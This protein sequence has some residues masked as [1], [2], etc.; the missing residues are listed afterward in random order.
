MN[1]IQKAFKRKCGLRMATGGVLLS[2]GRDN[3]L[4]RADQMGGAAD[5]MAANNN[6]PCG[7]M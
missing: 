6:A 1:N 4:T 3:Y 5:V 2:P 7:G